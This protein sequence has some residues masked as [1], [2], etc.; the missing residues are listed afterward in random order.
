MRDEPF[1]V[2]GT[3]V[4]VRVSIG[5]A[6]WPQQVGTSVELLRGADS[7]VAHAKHLGRDQVALSEPLAD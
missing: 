3:S 1:V 2:D 7:A 5:V 6:S 4:V